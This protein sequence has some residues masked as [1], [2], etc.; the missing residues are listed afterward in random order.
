MCRSPRR[1]GTAVAA[2]STDSAWACSAGSSTAGR[3]PPERW[4]PPPRRPAAP[5]HCGPGPAARR[6]RRTAGRAVGPADRRSAS[7]PG[8]GRT[9]CR[10]APGCVAGWSAWPGAVPARARRPPRSTGRD[11]PPPPATSRSL[12]LPPSVERCRPGVLDGQHLEA[13][14]QRATRGA[15]RQRA[16]GDHQ[17]ARH[18]VGDV[19]GPLQAAD[20]VS[21]G[22]MSRATRAALTPTATPPATPSATRRAVLGRS[23][24]TVSAPGRSPLADGRRRRVGR[25]RVGGRHRGGIAD[26]VVAATAGAASLCSLGAGTWGHVGSSTRWPSSRIPPTPSVRTWWARR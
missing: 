26:T 23:I 1:P 5:A 2:K 16:A 25:R 21:T 9:S 17:L 20:V 14:E 19:E 10:P 12:R 4:P 22:S 13:A 6:R 18:R 11:R 8:P 15:R 3:Q 7:R 24:E